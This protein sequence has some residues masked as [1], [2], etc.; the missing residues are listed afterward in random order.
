M[1]S[2]AFARYFSVEPSFTDATI[3]KP[4]NNFKLYELERSENNSLLKSLGFARMTSCS[5]KYGPVEAMSLNEEQDR[6]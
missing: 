4:E 1:H 6:T 2:C 5:V 3:P